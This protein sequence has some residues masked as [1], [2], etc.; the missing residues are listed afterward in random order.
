M[1]TTRLPPQPP[2]PEEDPGAIVDWPLLRQR[3]GFALRAVRRR[4]VLSALCFLAVASL[5]PLS[6]AAGSK[7]YRVEAVVKASRNAVVSTLADPVLLRSFDADDPASVARDVIL[8]RDGLAALVEETGLV[9]R[10]R[11]ARSPL[12][13]LRDGTLRFLGLPEPTRE[14]RVEALVERLEKRL[15]VSVPA[16][17]PGAPSGAPRDRVVLAIEW[18]DGPTAV[19][20][21]QAAARRFF[22]GRRQLEASMGQDALAAL[23]GRAADVRQEIEVKVGQVHEAELAMLRGN[24]AM[25]HTFRAPRGRVPQETELA[26]LR[27][28]LEARRLALGELER[29]QAARAEELRAQLERERTTYGERHPAMARTRELLER[30]AA[31]SPRAEALRKEIA[32]LEQ[33]FRV[34]SERAARLVDG[35][36]PALEYRRTELRLLLA[37]YTSLRDRL[38]GAR[39]ESNMARASFDRRY[40]FLVPPVLPRRPLWPVPALSIAASLLGGALLALLAAAALDAR[41]R[42]LLES[43]QLER[44][45]G[46]RVIGEI[47]A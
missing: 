13:R 28:T 16:T 3:L 6:L 11:A 33:E 30:T 43:W 7:T 25:A 31:P 10:T 2:R 42:R 26:Q 39:A 9:D 15:T 1:T 5:G 19:A 14:E 12:A 36:D 32:G 24:P 21:L 20:L 47:R 37:Q 29:L 38:D 17:Q 27:E 34:A 44:S 41:S 23:D 18:N 4:P 46:L 35:E 8:R 40:A 45:L 22:E